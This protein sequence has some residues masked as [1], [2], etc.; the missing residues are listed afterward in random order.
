MKR[1][2]VSL[3]AIGLATASTGAFAQQNDDQGYGD[4]RY[5]NDDSR[6]GDQRDDQRY[7]TPDE[8]DAGNDAGSYYD[9]ARVIRVDP[10]LAD[11]VDSH[12]ARSSVRR[13]HQ[14]TTAGQYDR[15]S[16]DDGYDRYS[17]D[18]YDRYYRDDG[19]DG[20]G[21]PRYGTQGGRT[22][23]T[24]IGGVVGAVL[25]SKI[26]SGSGSVAAAGVGTL[27]GS[28]AGR[29]IYDQHQRE[30]RSGTVVVCDPEPVQDDRYG[31]YDGGYDGSGVNGGAGYDVTYEYNGRQ[32]TRRMDYN[33]GDRI[34][35]RVAV[36][37]E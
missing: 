27:L 19:Y 18:R 9:Y 6:Y 8:G 32:Y 24:V 26:G 25:G 7:G 35:V 17:D 31:D 30:T 20:Y 2:L 5:G 36:S 14:R 1:L 10:V 37:A 15:Y 33:P 16:D 13:C 28:M 4:Q 29:E 12:Q 3:L 34:R 22:A 21:E 11:G 23:A